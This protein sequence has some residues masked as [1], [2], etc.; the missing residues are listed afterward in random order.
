MIVE[1]YAEIN[2]NVTR[3]IIIYLGIT[4]YLLIEVFLNFK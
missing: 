4:I 2:S 1:K 3:K